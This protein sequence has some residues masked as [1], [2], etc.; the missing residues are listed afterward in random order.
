MAA[1]LFD[2]D[3]SSDDWGELQGEPRSNK[4]RR[5]RR[6]WADMSMS[7]GS[8]LRKPEVGE[9]DVDGDAFSLRDF[10]LSPEDAMRGLVQGG[11]GFSIEKASEV[12]TLVVVSCRYCGGRLRKLDSSTEWFCELQPAEDGC[13]CNW[14]LHR[15]MWIAGE[16]RSKGRPRVQC[17]APSCKRKFDAER[18]RRHRL[19]IRSRGM[20][21]KIPKVGDGKK[22]TR[23]LSSLRPRSPA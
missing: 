13:E 14:C 6:P 20:S 21:H 19:L 5:R 10:R 4:G 2:P 16:L 17:G 8:P 11:H 12:P 22:L 15:E 7:D 18:Q 3:H 23:E 1:R 9:L